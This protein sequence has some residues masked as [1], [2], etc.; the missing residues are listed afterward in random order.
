LYDIYRPIYNFDV[1]ASD[2]NVSL[3]DSF[4]VNNKFD[5]F[6]KCSSKVNCRMISYKPNQTFCKHFKLVKY[7]QP[8]SNS[9]FLYE[10]IDS[11]L[12]SPLIPYLTNYWPFN[13]GLTDIVSGVVFSGGST[14]GKSFSNDRMNKDRSA[15]YLQNAYYNLP[16][17]IYLSGSCSLSVWVKLRSIT[18]WSSLLT[19]GTSSGITSSNSL[20]FGFSYSST[21]RPHLYACAS[22]TISP[23][24]LSIGKWHHLA[25]TFA[26]TATSIYVDGKLVVQNLNDCAA[27]NVNRIYNSLGASN[28]VGAYHYPPDADID[29]LKFFN[30]TL[31]ETEIMNDMNNYY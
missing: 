1:S 12:V 11:D 30:K 14:T 27:T 21:G 19:I 13:N 23:I 3:I 2:E 10:K 26:G 8:V 31:T 20:W 5:C 28:D 29:D 22:Y 15:L 18:V 16:S 9:L 24:D 25:Y 7:S 4:T 6:T 17:G